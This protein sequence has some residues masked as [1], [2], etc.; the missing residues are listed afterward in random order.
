M[1]KELIDLV[2]GWPN[3][4]RGIVEGLIWSVCVAGL[5]FGVVALAPIH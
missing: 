5:Y 1:I 2:G 3:A 4:V